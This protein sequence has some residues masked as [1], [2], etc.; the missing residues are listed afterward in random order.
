MQLL[1]CV[2]TF[3]AFAGDATPKRPWRRHLG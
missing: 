3:R 2:R 1:D